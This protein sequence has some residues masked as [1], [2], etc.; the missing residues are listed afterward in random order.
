MAHPRQ[1][2][3]AQP[4][5][6]RISQQPCKQEPLELVRSESGSRRW[7]VRRSTSTVTSR[8]KESP[9]EVMTTREE[10]ASTWLATRT[11]IDF[12]MQL[13]RVGDVATRWDATPTA[14]C[15]RHS[16]T[17]GSTPVARRLECGSP[18][19]RRWAAH[20]CPQPPA[21]PRVHSSIAARPG[22]GVNRAAGAGSAGG[23]SGLTVP[24]TSWWTRT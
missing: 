5:G 22:C 7:R 10:R 17:S 2:V 13:E 14:S 1:E 20:R 12:E 23:G 16:P 19:P 8:A 11:G 18:V 24:A 4:G 9:A 3:R 15:W 6:V 21:R